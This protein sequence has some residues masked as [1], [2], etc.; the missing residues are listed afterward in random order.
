MPGLFHA[1]RLFGLFG[2]LVVHAGR[3]RLGKQVWFIVHAILALPKPGICARRGT[4]KD[5]TDLADGEGAAPPGGLFRRRT[6]RLA[7]A[8]ASL[9]ALVLG[10]VWGTRDRLAADLIDRQL[11]ALGLP[12]HYRIES[13]ELGREVIGAVVVGDPAHPDLTVERVEIALR[14]GAAGPAIERITLVRPRLYGRL[15][16]GRVHFGAIDRLIYAP[17]PTGGVRLPNW[18]LALV[19]ARGRIDSAFGPLAFSADGN[20]RLADGFAGTLGVV[21]P[22]ARFGS[23]LAAR[24]TLFGAVTTS[25]GRPHLTGPLRLG[26]VRCGDTRVAGGQV[27]LAIA[28]DAALANWTVGGR[29]ALGR[30]D[31]G[32]QVAL[33]GLGGAAGL[34]WQAGQGGLAGQGGQAGQGEISGRITLDGHGLA[35]PLARLGEVRLDGVVHFG[36][37]FTAGDFRG[38]IDGS[39]LSR[40][41]AALAALDRARLGVAG[42]PLVPLVARATAALAR[43]EPGSHVSGSIGLHVE[44]TGWRLA[45]PRLALRGDHGNQTLAQVDRLVMV[46]GD[47]RIPRV[48]GNFSTGGADLPT[49]TG[50]MTAGDVRGAQFRLAMAPYTA[51]G[52]ALAVPGMAVSQVGDGSLGFSGTIALSG[53]LGQGR[54]DGLVLPVDGGLASDGHLALMRHC[55]TPGFA[56]L[57]VGTLDLVHGSVTLCPVNGAVVRAGAGGTTVAATLPAL[58]L[59]GRSGNAPFV[60]HAGAGRI[61]WPGTTTLAGVD[62]TLGKGADANRLHLS[63]ATI[64]SAGS[65]LAGS[66]S[67]GEFALAALPATIGAAAGDWRVDLGRISADGGIA[68][69]GGRFTLTDRTVPARFAPLAGRDATITLGQQWV[70]ASLRLVAPRAGD[71]LARVTLRHDGLTGK[72]HADVAI[73]GLTFRDGATPGTA[74]DKTAG[75]Q[76]SDLSD[77][78]KGVIADANGTIRGTARFDWDTHAANGGVTGNGRFSSDDFDFAAVLGP[79]EGLSGTIEF[80]DLIHFV[81]AP[82]QVLK[83]ASI[84]PGIEVD[85]GTIDLDLAE[86]QVVRLNRAEWPFEGGTIELEPTELHFGEVEPRKFTLII[87]GLAAATFLQR[88]NMSNLSATGTFDGRL[89]L[90]FDAN[91]GRITGGQLVS[92]A[93]GGNVSY[94]GALTYRDLSP[95]ANFA[96]RMLRSVDYSAMTVGMEGD[97]AG[98]VITKVSFGGIRQ[99]KG[100]E[101]N[102]ITRQLSRLPIRFDV[103]VRAQF[104]QLFGSLRSLYDPSLVRDPRD[105]GLVDA[106]GRPL[107]HHGPVPLGPPTPPARTGSAIQPQASGT[108]P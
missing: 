37:G 88:V 64:A 61:A 94:V 95:M 76:P 107:H 7:L 13:I 22:Q 23:C 104:Y 98:E 31:S 20:G 18:T 83:V 1:V 86:N 46:G 12:A 50:T 69:S 14:Y 67:G 15:D 34:R 35:T 56:R 51:A 9:V 93:P 16:Q 102:L 38:D 33:L 79:V 55:V 90:V 63:A 11:A 87:H 52:A 57:R 80:T 49:I 96:F 66:F 71:E 85:N 65:T 100:A 36:Q 58:T 47:G 91:G 62:V 29:L 40:G 25:A 5:R 30:I 82:H 99:G 103:N 97:L 77:L 78:A 53:P 84:N 41:P 8:G 74:T 59:E 6:G 2:F 89:P 21:V 19:D 92:R 68:L 24:T 17:S 75:L 81:T 3:T 39:S 72:G 108:M 48:A 60:L 106:H 32:K 4:M 73:P 45:V 10:G 28:G 101:R 26:A 105:L 44:P 54:I 43:A 27:D 42:T 70:N